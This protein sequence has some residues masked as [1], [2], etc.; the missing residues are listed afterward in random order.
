MSFVLPWRMLYIHL[1]P[2]LISSTIWLRKI[3]VRV[4]EVTNRVIIWFQI[5][6]KLTQMRH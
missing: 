1:K 6:D 5:L 2:E 4:K 3:D